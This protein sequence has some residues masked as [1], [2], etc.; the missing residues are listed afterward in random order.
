QMVHLGID[1][2][3]YEMTGKKKMSVPALILLIFTD[4]SI[5]LYTDVWLH[6][7]WHRAV[8][9]RRNIESNNGVYKYSSGNTIPV[10]DVEDRDLIRLK[11]DHPDEMVRLAAAGME[12]QN[13]LVLYLQRDIF[14]FRTPAVREI[15]SIAFNILNNVYYMQACSSKG[16]DLQTVQMNFEDRSGENVRDFV[17]YD[18]N[19]W[20]YDLFRPEDP[21]E[22]RGKHP[23][24]PGIDRYIKFSDGYD[25]QTAIYN[26]L[27]YGN[28]TRNSDLT[29]RERKYLRKQ[30]KLSY[31]N[32]IN[33]ALIG[34]GRFYNQFPLM[35]A[36]T[37]WTFSFAHYMAPFGY[38]VQGRLFI[39]FNDWNLVSVIHSYH[40][41]GKNSGGFEIQIHRK[42]IKLKRRY[43]YAGGSLHGWSQPRDLLFWS[44]ELREGG[45]I[46]L[47]G[48]FPLGKYLEISLEIT[49]KT[50]GW[51]PGSVYHNRE[52]EFRAGI[53]L[54]L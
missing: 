2:I 20:V 18:C 40:N 13:E 53:N 33:P 28:T 49:G 36:K 47:N 50:P 52:A 10:T 3:D 51:V 35:N 24:G 7:E 1:R 39:K 32:L 43:F 34:I 27:M 6:E 15:G 4:L 31:I 22:A 19:A 30:Y 48:S 25:P 44:N 41:A 37:E 12:A 9:G 45:M 17:G 11:R 8:M 16:A 26:Y 23:F 46:R 54:I 21:Y 5:S 14:I 38:S 42:K 29:N